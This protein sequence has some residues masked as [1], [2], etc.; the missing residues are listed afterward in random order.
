MPYP[1]GSPEIKPYWFPNQ[2]PYTAEQA[3][4]TITHECLLKPRCPGCSDAVSSGR[5]R[6]ELPPEAWLPIMRDIHEQY[7]VNFFLFMGGE[8]TCW[9][10]I[11][12]LTRHAADSPDFDG[13]F[14]TAGVGLLDKSGARPTRLL[15]RLIEEGKI[16]QLYL[17]ASVDWLEV[18]KSPDRGDASK[19]KAWHGLRLMRYLRERFPDAALTIHQVI[20]PDN[21]DQMLPLYEKA[22]ELGVWYSCC[23]FIWRQYVERPEVDSPVSLGQFQGLIL[24]EKHKPELERNV[25]ELVKREI[26]WLQTRKPRSIA[27]SRAFLE[28]IPTNGIKQEYNCAAGRPRMFDVHTDGLV[29]WCVARDA[30]WQGQQCPGCSFVCLDRIDRYESLSQISPDQISWRNLIRSKKAPGYTLDWYN[31]IP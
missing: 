24:T 29:R 17:L 10:G 16:H 5:G 30:V 27:I 12:Q 26:E 11:E 13:G 31:S 8:P 18:G 9:K 23:P 15:K 2:G 14:Y 3:E 4:F 21:V 6:K 7:G 1:E 22:Q 28:Q 25:K 19:F 20:K